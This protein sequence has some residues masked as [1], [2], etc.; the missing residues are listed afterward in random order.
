MPR[1]LGT[2][3]ENRM[4]YQAKDSK[5]NQAIQK[6][7]ARGR[8]RLVSSLGSETSLAAARYESKALQGVSAYTKRMIESRRTTREIGWLQTGL[9]I[10]IVCDWL[11]ETWDDGKMSA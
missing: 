3:I 7:T 5:G 2:N 6:K 1:T 11:S 4:R 8:I 9:L 10:T